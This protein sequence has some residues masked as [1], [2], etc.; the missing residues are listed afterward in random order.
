MQVWDHVL[1]NPPW[2]YPYVVL[3]YLLSSRVAILRADRPADCAALQSRP[4]TMDAARLLRRAAMA[5]ETT[6]GD[7]R[8]PEEPLRG[9]PAGAQYTPFEGPYPPQ[10]LQAQRGDRV[11]LLGQ[12]TAIVA[13]RR[14][15]AEMQVGRH[16]H[17]RAPGA[18]ALQC[19]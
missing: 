7:A 10:A 14:T 15:L 8:M 5:L 1:C 19:A 2:F 6:P 18:Q 17:A 3:S 16:S 11:R 12:R 9:L 4:A 13:Q